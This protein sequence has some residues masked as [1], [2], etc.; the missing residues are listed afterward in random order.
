VWDLYGYTVQR[1][2]RVPAMIERDDHIPPLAELVA[3]LDQARAVEA[4]ALNE[5]IAA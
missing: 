5:V 3:E 4:V 2:G 1:L